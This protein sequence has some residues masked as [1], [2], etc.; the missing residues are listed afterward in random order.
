MKR[1][2][3]HFLISIVFCTFLTSCESKWEP[4]NISFALVGSSND[5]QVRKASKS[6]FSG[7]F[8]Y[9]PNEK[10]IFYVGSD[11][12]RADRACEKEREYKFVS[13]EEPGFYWA[14][15]IGDEDQEV[16]FPISVIDPSGEKACLIIPT[17]TYQA[18]SNTGGHNFYK[19]PYITPLTVS[20]NRPVSTQSSAHHGYGF[21]MYK[22]L[23]SLLIEPRVIDDRYLSENPSILSNCST[24]IF[25][26]HSEYWSRTMFDSVEDYIVS[27]GDVINISGNIAYWLID[28]DYSNELITVDKRKSMYSE[29]RVK[30]AKPA[31][32]Y[33]FGG[34]YQ[35]YPISRSIKSATEYENNFSVAV[36]AGVTFSELRMMGIEDPSHPAFK[37]IENKSGVLDDQPLAVELDGVVL[38]EFKSGESDVKQ[39]RSVADVKGALLS[40]WVTYAKQLKH[41]VLARDYINVY[42]GRVLFFGSIGWPEAALKNGQTAQITKS[43]ISNFFSKT[44]VC[45]DQE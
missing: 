18:Y 41:I 9:A 34:Y 5:N 25:S 32:Q 42:G 4:D 16:A 6:S 8:T 31:A 43:A 27:G 23:R 15:A 33:Y 40:G 12:E 38:R 1:I 17:F 26:G 2:K 14:V 10:G 44:Y 39:F 13:P 45:E 11:C 30:I 21:S 3:R 24:L 28:I 20:L 35:G 29:N 19:T 7:R 22:I 37:C 36:E